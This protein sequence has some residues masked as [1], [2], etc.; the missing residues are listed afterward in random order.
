M[1]AE[2]CA[3]LCP[4]LCLLLFARLLFR[5]F[6]AE[7]VCHLSVIK[8]IYR[9]T[10]KLKWRKNMSDYEEELLDEYECD[11]EYDDAEEM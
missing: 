3:S 8:F 5:L 7:E 4:L 9:S 11:E 2:V 1:N 10:D 6:K